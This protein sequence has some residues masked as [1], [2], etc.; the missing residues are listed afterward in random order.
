MIIIK[1]TQNYQFEREGGNGRNCRK[2][3]WGARGRKGKEESDKIT[4]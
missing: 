3:I 2:E 4:F 1:K